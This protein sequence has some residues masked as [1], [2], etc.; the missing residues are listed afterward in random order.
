MNR[1]D[2]MEST[3]FPRATALIICERIIQDVNT[4]RKSVVDIFDML[5]VPQLPVLVA[6][7]SIYAAKLGSLSR[8]RAANSMTAFT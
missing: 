8:L 3:E 1:F 7:M 2:N 4:N 5:I 6:R